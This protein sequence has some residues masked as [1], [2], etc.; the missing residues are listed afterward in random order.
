MYK[1]S[2]DEEIRD[3]IIFGEYDKTKYMGGIRRYS[4]L[5]VATLNYLIA[6]GFADPQDKQNEAPTIE[7]FLQF[8]EKHPKFTAH[9]YVV[10]SER[11][12]YRLSVEGVQCETM[13]DVLDV[14]DVADFGDMF[15][16][17]DEF[18]VTPTFA[19]CWYD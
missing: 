13:G 10:S 17:A 19:W 7:E 9:G 11:E 3:K 12:D 5:D 16:D 6:M 8:L 1:Y 2:K 4:N 15:H 14:N 18:E